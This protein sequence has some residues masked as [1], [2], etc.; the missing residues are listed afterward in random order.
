MEPQLRF[1]NK[2]PTGTKR[3]LAAGDRGHDA[4]FVSRL[5]GTAFLLKEA[6]ILIVEVDV[7]ERTDISGFVE[8]SLA[9]PRIRFI[10]GVD[11]RANGS[12]FGLNDFKIVRELAQRSRD[13]NA[14][15]HGINRLD[16]LF[17]PGLFQMQGRISKETARL[18][19]RQTEYIEN[20]VQVVVPIKLDLDGTFVRSGTKLHVGRKVLLQPILNVEHRRGESRLGRLS[21]ARC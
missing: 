21:V 10:E 13:S 5:Y 16:R 19:G 17:Y 20:P 3:L 4:D 9:Q 18:L 1:A 2:R 14:D 11:H 15:R 6:N 12:T 7:D 8:D